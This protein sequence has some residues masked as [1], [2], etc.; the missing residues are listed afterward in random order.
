M[1]L[2]CSL[3]HQYTFIFLFNMF[4]EGLSPKGSFALKRDHWLLKSV[5][6]FISE[7]RVSRLTALGGAA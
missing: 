6:R 1:E 3:G 7:V 5:L 2:I 4:S